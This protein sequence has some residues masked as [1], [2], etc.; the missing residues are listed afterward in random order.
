MRCDRALESQW[1]LSREAP[2]AGHRLSALIVLV[3]LSPLASSETLNGSRRTIECLLASQMIVSDANAEGLPVKSVRQGA[4]G[5]I[6]FDVGPGGTLTLLNKGEMNIAYKAKIAVP[7]LAPSIGTH[8]SS[9]VDAAHTVTKRITAV[10]N[11]HRIKSISAGLDPTSLEKLNDGLSQ[12]NSK[13]TLVVTKV[14]Q[15]FKWSGDNCQ[16]DQLIREILTGPN[17]KTIEVLFDRELCERIATAIDPSIL[18][19][20]SQCV[21]PLESILRVI[22]DRGIEL[23]KQAMN[24]SLPPPYLSEKNGAKT[25]TPAYRLDLGQVFGAL[26]SCGFYSGA[27]GTLPLVDPPGPSG[28][29]K[30]SPKQRLRTAF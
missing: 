8:N 13:S 5:E 27:Q 17:T 7:D 20:I 14:T 21:A 4:S 12:S 24:L 2:F 3:A 18:D 10:Q 29:L 28:E 19:A 26:S 15:T 16:R 1:S 9:N 25:Q 6:F 11:S 30:N 22:S 23:Q